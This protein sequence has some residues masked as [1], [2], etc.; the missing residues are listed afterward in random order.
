M[1]LGEITFDSTFSQPAKVINSVLDIIW[2]FSLALEAKGLL[3]R[4]EIADVLALVIADATKYEGGRS[5]RIIVAE[6]MLRGF[7]AL[8]PMPGGA[9]MRAL[10]RVID[11]DAARSAD[12]CPLDPSEHAK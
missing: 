5:D 3:T 10:F 8:P 12:A 9:P 11:G 7:T 1:T 4:S 2:G 6:L